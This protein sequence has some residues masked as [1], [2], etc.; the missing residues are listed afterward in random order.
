MIVHYIA[1]L[2]H[3]DSFRG[4]ALLLTCCQPLVCRP[5]EEISQTL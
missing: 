3:V 1:S 2:Q 4:F 5:L